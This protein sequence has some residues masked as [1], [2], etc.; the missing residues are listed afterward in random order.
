MR[1]TFQVVRTV[2]SDTQDSLNL[3]VG[4]LLASEQSEDPVTLHDGGPFSGEGLTDCDLKNRFSRADRSMLI[5]KVY[6]FRDSVSYI[7]PGALGALL[8]FDGKQ[9]EAVVKKNSC[10]SSY[11]S[12]GLNAAVQRNKLSRQP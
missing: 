9:A 4:S 6:V 3:L 10:K 11:D 7:G 2:P 8:V 5:A 1:L 12:A